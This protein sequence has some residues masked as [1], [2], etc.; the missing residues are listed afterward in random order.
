M[1]NRELIALL[2]AQPPDQEAVLASTEGDTAN[3]IRHVSTLLVIN[4]DTGRRKSV[5]AIWD[6]EYGDG[7]TYE[8]RGDLNNESV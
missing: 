3:T 8:Q 5:V 6:C 1:K 7:V 2:Q 4:P